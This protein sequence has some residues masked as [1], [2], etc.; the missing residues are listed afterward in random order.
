MF[1]LPGMKSFGRFEKEGFEYNKYSN[2]LTKYINITDSVCVSVVS[3]IKVSYIC[4]TFSVNKLS[5]KSTMLVTNLNYNQDWI[6]SV[7]EI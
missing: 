6:S 1:Q 2:E 3:E 7:Y 5:S 4:K